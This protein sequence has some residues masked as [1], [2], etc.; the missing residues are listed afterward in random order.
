M[1]KRTRRLPRER[2]QESIVTD[3]IHDLAMVVASSSCTVKKVR[4]SI[5]A[6]HTIDV[7]LLA[8]AFVLVLVRCSP[9]SFRCSLVDH[10]VVGRACPLLAASAP[11]FARLPPR[12]RRPM[13]SVHPSPFFHRVFYVTRETLL[14]VPHVF[15]ARRK[16]FTR[17]NSFSIWNQS[18]F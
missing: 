8:D 1:S 5:R 13:A 6:A 4:T 17:D 7:L 3:I 10:C 9:R 16:T 2:I 15:D 14:S 18:Q 12:R 11:M